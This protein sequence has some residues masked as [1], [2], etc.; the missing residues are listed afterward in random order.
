MSNLTKFDNTLQDFS[1]EVGKLK[2]VSA[3]YQKLNALSLAYDSITKQFGE[4]SAELKEVSLL[5]KEAREKLDQGI[6]KLLADAKRSQNEIG[7]AVGE[8][9]ELL[10]KDNKTF[11]KELEGT[12]KIKLDDNRSQIKQLIENERSRIKDIFE[13]E[14]SKN[15]QE[16]KK[17]MIADNK[18][19]TLAILKGQT[20]IKI[21]I[22]LIGGAILLLLF[23]NTFK[24]IH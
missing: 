19:Q 8:K 14:F 13:I 16:L 23:A 11:F 10:S 15:T 18:Q 6:V 1:Q 21:S 17:T 3:A 12:L 2:E 20:A 9:L 5:L 4:N 7:K 24:L 22:W